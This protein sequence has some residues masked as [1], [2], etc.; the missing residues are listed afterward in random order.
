MLLIAF[1]WQNFAQ[2][3]N[4]GI[5]TVAA[6]RK[7][8]G[9]TI[10]YDPAYQQI[11]Y[12]LGDIAIETGVC[13]DVIIRALREQ[14]IDLQKEVHE[15]MK[16][17]FSVYPKNWGLTKPDRNI[18]HRRVPNL[19]KFLERKHL[20]LPLDH[21]FQAGDIVTWNLRNHGY[22]PH[23]GI[24]S[25]QKTPDNIPLVIHNIGLGTVEE[26]VLFLYKITGHYRI[27]KD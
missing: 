13:A 20:S 21:D 22:L 19:A 8:I 15:D 12:P 7:Q 26:N 23:I 14:N 5:K 11:A 24:V 3:E 1:F 10:S 4:F 17:N 2:A 25:H 27:R 9:I 18:D 6:A 16:Q